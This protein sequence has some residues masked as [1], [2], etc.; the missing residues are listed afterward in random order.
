MNR[1][2]S[3]AGFLLMVVGGGL[4]I[5]YLTAP[6]PWYAALDKPPFNP[7]NWLFGP[8]WSLLYVLIAVA[9]WRIWPRDLKGRLRSLWSAQLVLNFFW[10][11]AFFGLRSPALALVVILLLLATILA[12]I[13][14]AQRCDRLAAALF[15][16]Y[17]A[18]VA[19]AT[20]LNASI[21]WLN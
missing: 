2:F 8:V 7:P 16:P 18:W 13:A 4:L 15:L 5:G 3:L 11:I 9:G 10:P 14:Q 6:G 20:V 12:F 17:A 1:I 21:W 19:F